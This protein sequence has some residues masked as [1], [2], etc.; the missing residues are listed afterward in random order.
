MGGGNSRGIVAHYRGICLKWPRRSVE[1][2]RYG[3]KGIGPKSPR[4]ERRN[5]LHQEIGLLD[6]QASKIGESPDDIQGI[7]LAKA[8]L[9]PESDKLHVRPPEAKKVM[10]T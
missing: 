7:L 9:T 2:C 6:F 4:W 3:H 1:Y 5:F 8:R 10:H